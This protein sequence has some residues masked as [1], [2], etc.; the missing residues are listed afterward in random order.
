MF[1]GWREMNDYMRENKIDEVAPQL[2]AAAAAPKPAD[3]DEAADAAEANKAAE[4]SADKPAA[5]SG[6]AKSRGH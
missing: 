4:K 2:I 5:K 6:G 3:G 1:A